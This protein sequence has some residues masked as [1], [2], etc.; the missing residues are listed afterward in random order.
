M[1]ESILEFHPLLRIAGQDPTALQ[2]LSEALSGDRYPIHGS[3]PTQDAHSD[4]PYQIDLSLAVALDSNGNVDAPP[5]GATYAG[6]TP[7]QRGAFLAWSQ[8]PVRPAPPAFQ[9]LFVA[10]LEVGLLDSVDSLQMLQRELIR[11]AFSPAWHG[12]EWHAR[13]LL[14][15]LWLTSNGEGIAEWTSAID[16]PVDVLE[17]A[18]G[19]QALLSKD[20][21]AAQIA[22]LAEAWDIPG[23]RTRTSMLELRMRSLIDSLEKPPLD[24]VREAITA[25]ELLPRPWR[26]AH[27]SLR[28]SIPQ[29]VI[30]PILRPLLAE[31]FG[32]TREGLDAEEAGPEAG[33]PANQNMD[34]QLVLEFGHSRSEFYGHVLDLAHR[35]PG[36]I[37]LL[38]EDRRMVH[39]ITIR[40]S[41]M[42]RF[43]RIWDYAQNWSSARVY[44]NGEEVERW[45][46][47]PH[48]QYLR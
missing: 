7:V 34:W 48:S 25:E 12:N 32:I 5:S 10:H 13:A 21:R 43:W 28:F 46:L 8:D 15:A 31:L 4:D 24:I 23:E 47:W 33:G 2:A 26:T 36:Y 1:P 19:L 42:R 45:K 9:R 35:M 38:D 37:Q 16:V 44:L 14:L 41:E 17:L 11:W 27:R 3:V 39:R 40:K 6:L 18:V 22:R 20:L 29:P 30:R